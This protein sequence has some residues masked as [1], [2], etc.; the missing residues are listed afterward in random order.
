[1]TAQQKIEA[2][3]LH[4]AMAAAFAE[5][6]G[7]TKSA[8][9]A[10]FKQGG[11][12]S[13]YADLNSVIDA[14]KPPL[15]AHGLFFTQ[16]PHESQ[17]G[18]TVETMLHHA[19][20]ESI[21]LGTL[22]VPANKNDA[23]GYGSALTYAR[24]YGLVTA[25]G[26]PV[27]DDDGNA[28]VASASKAAEEDGPID[29][30]QFATLIQLIEVTGTDTQAFTNYFKTASVKALPKSKYDTALKSLQA[31]VAKTKEPA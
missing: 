15:I 27:E 13:R 25:F 22:F 8:E 30:G 20:G 23:H 19:S 21:S 12:V 26:V 5:I 29:D 2:S 28:A 7:A 10:A 9:N 1:M 3:S 11:K 4:S 31:K 18:V 17:G 24:R 14:I 6:E 16:H